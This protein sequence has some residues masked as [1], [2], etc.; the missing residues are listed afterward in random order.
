MAR[1]KNPKAARPA[2]YARASTTVGER[3]ISECGMRRNERQIKHEITAAEDHLT[4]LRRELFD[5]HCAKFNIKPGDFVT[6]AKG[7]FL[8]ASIDFSFHSP[9][10]KGYRQLKSGTFHGRRQ[11]LFDKWK[12]I[13]DKTRIVALEEQAQLCGVL[14]L[15]VHL[16]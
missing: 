5:L 12:K 4:A 15:N 10:L 11:H 9:W 6:T 1:A 13:N 14:P 8:V 2:D 16:A 7:T 3:D